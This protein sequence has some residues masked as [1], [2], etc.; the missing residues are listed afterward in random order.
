VNA[1]AQ[2]TFFLAVEGEDSVASKALLDALLK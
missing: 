2:G 1:V